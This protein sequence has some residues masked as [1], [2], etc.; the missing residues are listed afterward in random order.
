[1]SQLSVQPV[2]RLLQV[3][4]VLSI[5]GISKPTLY[6]GIKAGTLP[7][8]VRISARRVGW[9]STDIARVV[10]GNACVVGGQ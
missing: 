6:R 8:P 4:A 7:P 5:L 1:M 2:E 9:R 10:A 3:G